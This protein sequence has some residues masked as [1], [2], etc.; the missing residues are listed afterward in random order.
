MQQKYQHTLAVNHLL[1]DWIR[2]IVYPFAIAI[3]PPNANQYTVS[4]VGYYNNAPVTIL[5][6]GVAVM[7]IYMGGHILL[8]KDSDTITVS[9]NA[10]DV[11]IPNFNSTYLSQFYWY[12]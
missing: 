9:I 10:Y 7:K 3:S 12:S 8:F 2:H 4:I 1:Q 6:F 11:I 5:L